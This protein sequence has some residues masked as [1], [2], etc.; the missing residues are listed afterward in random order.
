MKKVCAVCYQEVKEN[1]CAVCGECESMILTN[2]A[3]EQIKQLAQ[4]YWQVD[5]LIQSL[6][7]QVRE[8]EKQLKQASRRREELETKLDNLLGLI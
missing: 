8:L 4:E 7:K 3:Y 5:D 6:H 2:E 1:E